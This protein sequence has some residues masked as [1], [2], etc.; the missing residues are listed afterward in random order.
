M[1]ND[2]DYRE[3]IM[4]PLI[5]DCQ[6]DFKEFF[7]APQV[8]PSILNTLPKYRTGDI[9]STSDGKIG[10]VTK[11]CSQDGQGLLFYLIKSGGEEMYY[12][13]IQIQKI[14]GEE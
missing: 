2:S 5:V 9:V 14:K 4:N 12:S 11:G 6:G 10:I 13:G 3:P 8:H 7:S 1:S